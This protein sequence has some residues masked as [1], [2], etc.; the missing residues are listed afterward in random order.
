MAF[1]AEAAGG[2]PAVL[3]GRDQAAKPGLAGTAL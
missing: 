3:R 2:G 1:H